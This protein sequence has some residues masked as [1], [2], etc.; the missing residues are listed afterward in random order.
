[1]ALLFTPATC[2]FADQIY[3]I[4]NS[5]S[6]DTVPELRDGNNDWHI[7]CNK[8]LQF[9]FDNPDAHCVNSSIPWTDALFD[10]TYDYVIVQP[11]AG[12]SLDQDVAI[13]STWM[14]LQPGATFVIHPGW[15]AFAN[16]P[17]MY[18]MDNT[19]NQMRPS[20]AYINSLIAALPED[21][22]V[23]NTRSHDI[24][25]SVFQDIQAGVG[26]YDSLS[27]LYRDNIHMTFSEGRYLMHNSVRKALGQPLSSD[28]FNIESSIATYLNNKI[29][30]IP[31]PASTW[32]M[33][34][35]LLLRRRRRAKKVA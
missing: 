20:P 26:P 8:N 6:W 31:E 3:Q 17:S 15:S 28:G 35:P 25:Y 27:D 24:L 13:I 11:F 23:L 2:G 34:F 4:G 5:L 1:M 32:A 18:V 12:T 21:R 14:Q 7:Y 9:I 33:L 19:D 10:N 29:L 30:S 22:T 16:F